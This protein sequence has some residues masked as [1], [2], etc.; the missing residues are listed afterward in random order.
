MQALAEARMPHD[1]EQSERAQRFTE[2][3]REWWPDAVQWIAAN[4]RCGSQQDALFKLSDAILRRYIQA[5]D[6]Y[7]EPLSPHLFPDRLIKEI[8]DY[9]HKPSDG[10]SYAKAWRRPELR[11]LISWDDL[12]KVWPPT[13]GGPVKCEDEAEAVASPAKPPN[14]SEYAGGDLQPSPL[15]LRQA[16]I[17][18]INEAIGAVY[19]DA[20]AATQK[21]PNVKQI[22]KPVKSKL[23]AQG[24]E[25]SGRHIQELAGAKVY[26]MRR[27][28]Q[29][30]TVASE[31]RKQR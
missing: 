26:K 21:P 7:L 17:D 29:G 11:T 10:L 13:S 25:A 23:A 24:F 16:P 3:F 22:V 14:A 12:L 2:P 8:S 4:D 19:D 18:K 6:G 27:R 5:V 20:A 9:Q 31:K 15:E 1:A 28:K 30:P